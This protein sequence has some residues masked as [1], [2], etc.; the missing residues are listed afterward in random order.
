MQYSGDI[1]LKQTFVECSSNILKT[2]LRDYWNLPK[3]RHLLL[4]NYTLLTQKQLFYREL[5]KKPFPLKCYLNVP[6]MSRT[7]QR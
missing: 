7:L 4:S 2:L 3:D 1:F 5:L 6:W